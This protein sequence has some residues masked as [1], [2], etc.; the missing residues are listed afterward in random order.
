MND[1]KSNGH[2]QRCLDLEIEITVG[3]MLLASIK[4]RG[5]DET[6][7]RCLITAEELK[8]IM[9]GELYDYNFAERVMDVFFE[10]EKLRRFEIQKLRRSKRYLGS[11]GGE[12]SWE[13]VGEILG[14]DRSAVRYW[15]EGILENM[16]SEMH[17][18]EVEV[19]QDLLSQADP[20]DF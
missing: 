10:E 13:V 7:M 4:K 18:P 15:A 9:A 19:A 5:L 11:R 3:R 16:R 12:V 17:S 2:E 20:L 6:A 8:A 14:L 1:D